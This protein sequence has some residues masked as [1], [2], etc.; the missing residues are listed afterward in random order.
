MLAYGQHLEMSKSCSISYLSDLE[1]VKI[2]ILDHSGLSTYTIAS[3]V[4][5]GQTIVY[6]VLQTFDYKTFNACDRTCISK[7]KTIEHEDRILIR[8]AKSNNDQTYCDIICIAGI[9]VFP[10]TLKCCLKEVD[11]YLH[12]FCK[13]PVLKL[14]H[15]AE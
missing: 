8:T 3:E 14:L 10:S 6:R 4:L 7:Q 12:I 15:K 5:H 1:I 9:K 11:L 13:N 2:L